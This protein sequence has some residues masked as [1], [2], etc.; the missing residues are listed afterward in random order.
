MNP[1][2]DLRHGLL[3]TLY[4]TW[5]LYT[6]CDVAPDMHWYMVTQKEASNGYKLDVF[7]LYC[8]HLKTPTVH[9]ETVSWYHHCCNMLQYTVYE[10]I[11]KYKKEYSVGK[12]L[13]SSSKKETKIKGKT[14]ENERNTNV[15]YFH[16]LSMDVSDSP[17]QEAPADSLVDCSE[18]AKASKPWNE[19][20][21]SPTW[22]AGFFWPSCWSFVD[23]VAMLCN[24]F[25]WSS[26]LSN[27]T[28]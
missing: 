15:S 8:V 10:I 13:N 22:E 28:W 25:Q 12:F 14:K 5:I 26:I 7:L 2:H 21:V 9:T 11:Q 20:C 23:R 3:P 18:V 1:L 16:H 24:K 6:T 17:R 19:T 27:Q 4:I